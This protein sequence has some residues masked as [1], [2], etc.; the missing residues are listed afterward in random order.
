[1]QFDDGVICECAANILLIELSSAFLPPGER[2][3]PPSNDKVNNNCPDPADPDE[4]TR[5][6]RCRWRKMI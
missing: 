3:L 2:P 1:M 4:A 5:N 6:G